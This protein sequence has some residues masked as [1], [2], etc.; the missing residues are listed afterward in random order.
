[1]KIKENIRKIRLQK[2][3]FSYWFLLPML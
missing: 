3:V 2:S 1:M